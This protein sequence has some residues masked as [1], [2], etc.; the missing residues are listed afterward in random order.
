M[1]VNTDGGDKHGL[2]LYSRVMVTQGVGCLWMDEF[3]FSFD[4]QGV[5]GLLLVAAFR[6]NE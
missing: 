2:L 3:T 6:L 5:L 1:V 4:S